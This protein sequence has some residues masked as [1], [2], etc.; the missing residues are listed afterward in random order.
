METVHNNVRNYQCAQCQY[1]SYSLATMNRHVKQ[2]HLMTPEER[3][4]VACETCGTRFLNKHHL[5]R[6]VKTVHQNIKQYRCKL[7]NL[8]FSIKSNLL[9][10]IGTKHMGFKSGKAWRLP[11]NKQVRAE[12]AGH[13]AY[14]FL[15]LETSISFIQQDPDAENVI[16]AEAVPTEVTYIAAEALPQEAE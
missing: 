6:H 7:C 3:K 15:P 13:K 12:A 2:V 5:D 11:A 16:T 14:E 10:H 9:E 1:T 4:K 8:Y